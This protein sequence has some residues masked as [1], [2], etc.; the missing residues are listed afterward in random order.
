MPQ[1]CEGDLRVVRR[2]LVARLLEID[3]APG[4]QDVRADRQGLAS[5]Q[6][7]VMM[8]RISPA[9]RTSMSRSSFRRPL[10]KSGAALSSTLPPQAAICAT[11]EATSRPPSGTAC[12]N[13]LCYRGCCLCCGASARHR[14]SYQRTDAAIATISCGMAT[15]SR[16][17][18]RRVAMMTLLPSPMAWR[19]SIAAATDAQQICR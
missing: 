4:T 9:I 5:G 19:P 18:H 13:V 3:H 12:R 8:S 14:C 17:Y 16:C 1:G 2:E 6:R 11:H 15:L 10:S 7:E